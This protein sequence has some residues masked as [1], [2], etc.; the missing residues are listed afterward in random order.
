MSRRP[1]A[2][3]STAA[4]STAARFEGRI[5]GIGTASGTRVVIG[6]WERSPLGRFTDVMIE[7]EA[8]HRLLLAPSDEVADYVSST[9]TFDQVRVVPV[10]TRRVDGGIAVT[11]G[12]L[13]VRLTVG[14]ISPL[15][16]LM[17]LVPS[18]LATEPL[19]LRLIDP[20]AR[21]LVRGARTAG[22][23]GGGK[24]EYYGVTLVRDVSAAVTT[25]A[26]VDLGPLAPL[27]PPVRFGFGSAPARPSLVDVVTTIR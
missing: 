16:V 20:V 26:G 1:H 24:R 9:Y 6:M 3:R 4:R 18:R 12:E 2:A 5:A 19:W 23:A 14:G 10:E 13:S 15:G 22:S 11:A 17:R 25:Q 21:V 27:S 7:D 8:G